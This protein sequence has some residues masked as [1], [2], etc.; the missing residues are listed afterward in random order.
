MQV[1]ADIFVL[2]R[3]EWVN[4]GNTERFYSEFHKIHKMS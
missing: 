1:A 4:F 3:V 2:H